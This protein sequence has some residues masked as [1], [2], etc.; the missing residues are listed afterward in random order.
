MTYRLILEYLVIKI[1]FGIYPV[2][3]WQE[4]RL[5]RVEPSTTFVGKIRFLLLCREFLALNRHWKQP[6]I[7][8]WKSYVICF[9]LTRLLS[10]NCCRIV[11]RKLLPLPCWEFTPRTAPLSRSLFW[12]IHSFPSAS[13]IVFE[14]HPPS[15]IAHCST[16]LHLNDTMP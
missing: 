14:T 10:E 1:F 6:I 9:K 12:V 7:A 2:V 3:Q 8:I 15:L 5:A 4:E 11:G 16:T 13:F